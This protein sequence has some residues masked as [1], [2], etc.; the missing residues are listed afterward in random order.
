MHNYMYE[1]YFWSHE[2]QYA[3]NTNYMYELP[4]YLENEN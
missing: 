2:F 4:I 1:H 3:H